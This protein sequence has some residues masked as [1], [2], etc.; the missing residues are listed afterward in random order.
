MSVARGQEA[1]ELD[2]FSD[3]GQVDDAPTVALR[4]PGAADPDRTVALPRPALGST[5][6]PRPGSIAL[7]PRPP[8]LS[9]LRAWLHAVR[10]AALPA[11][12]LGGAVGGLL[13]SRDATAR[14]GLLAVGLLLLVLGHALAG[15][16]RDLGD[17]R[18][19]RAGRL[20]RAE[21]GR[22]ALAVTAAALVTVAVL[23]VV[24]DPRGLLLVPLGAVAVV[25]AVSRRTGAL[26][27]AVAG[28]LAGT[29]AVTTV[30]WAGSGRLDG[31]S[32]L[33]GLVV[34]GVLA[35][36]LAARRTRVS[37]RATRLLVLLPYLAAGGA[38]WVAALPWPV[39]AVALALPAART[40]SSA[41]ASA[42]SSARSSAGSSAGSSAESSAG[43]RPARRGAGAGSVVAGHARLF[44]LLLVAGLVV[45]GVTGTDLPLA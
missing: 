10:P 20:R 36:L 2:L 41:G 15:L 3:G 29:L 44:A 40:A 12:L 24:H 14:P 26:L 31:R 34:G 43:Q 38:V 1:L 6:R 17:A 13:V 8:A 9:P 4:R 39:L 19:G 23:G 5:A 18:P 42:A 32:A 27:A 37:A 33:A 45:A 11:T 35:G 30:V 25:L 16:A 28:L 7:P 22:A 21:A